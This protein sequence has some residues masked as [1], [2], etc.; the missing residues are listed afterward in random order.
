MIIAPEEHGHNAGACMGANHRTDRGD[1]D[2]CLRKPGSNHV[3]QLRSDLQTVNVADDD[4]LGDL[5]HPA[6][7]H[8]GKQGLQGFFLPSGFAYCHQ[9]TT[10]IHMNQGLDSKERPHCGRGGTD[11]AAVL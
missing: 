6:L 7:F 2:F 10:F 8:I 9:F 4:L 3:P 1:I 5:R 11:P